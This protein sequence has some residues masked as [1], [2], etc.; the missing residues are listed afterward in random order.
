M[1]EHPRLDE[2]LETCPERISLECFEGDCAA[3]DWDGPGACLHECHETLIEAIPSPFE[4]KLA[5]VGWMPRR[6]CGW[7]FVILS[8]GTLPETT[9]ICK[10]CGAIHFP[11]VPLT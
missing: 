11:G 6:T 8:E 7:C 4:V 9:D 10:P 2:P 5:E 3:C 1:P